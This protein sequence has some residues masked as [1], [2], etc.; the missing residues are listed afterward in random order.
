MVMAGNTR[1]NA[2][3]LKKDA[4]DIR[5]KANEY[6]RKVDEMYE[7]IEANVKDGNEGN[8]YGPRAREFKQDVN[9]L[10]TSFESIKSDLYKASE[11]LDEQADIW[12]RFE[13]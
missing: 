12:I 1:V 2:P 6:M 8:W 4:S 13:G 5:A 10:K 7:K 11:N 9:S 3:G